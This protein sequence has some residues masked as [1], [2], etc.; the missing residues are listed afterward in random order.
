VVG[1]GVTFLVAGLPNRTGLLVGALAGI[2]VG[3]VLER[4]RR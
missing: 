3:F 2:M 1:A 4:A